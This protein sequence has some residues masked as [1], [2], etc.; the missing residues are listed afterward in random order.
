MTTKYRDLPLTLIAWLFILMGMGVLLFALFVALLADS[1]HIGDPLG[2][3]QPDDLW[4]IG[5]A[6]IAFVGGILLLKRKAGGRWLILAW[7][8]FHVLIGIHHPLPKLITHAVLL[9]IIG[10]FLFQPAAAVYFTKSHT[11]SPD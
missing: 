2:R 9:L 8:I 11:R 1:S 6:L 5:S 10:Y 3:F 7:L 4:A